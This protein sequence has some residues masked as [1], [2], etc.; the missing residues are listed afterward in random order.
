VRRR[1]IGL[2][3]IGFGVFAVTFGLMLRFYAYPQLAKLPLNPNQGAV[4]TGKASDLLMVL[5]GGADIRVHHDVPMTTTV[6]IEG[7]LL[8]PDA[9]PDGDITV[10]HENGRTTDD[11]GHVISAYN[12][13]M[14]INRSTGAEAVGCANG[15]QYV[16]NNQ[17]AHGRD[18]VT[19]LTPQGQ[20][21]TFP[22]NTQKH[23]YQTFDVTLGGPAQADYVG[24]DTINGLSVYKFVA[25][26]PQSRLSSQ[27]VPGSLVGLPQ[28]SSV[29]VDIYYSNVRT[30]WVEPLTGTPVQDQEQ[31]HQEMRVVNADVP[32]TVVYNATLRL[33]PASV[34]SNVDAAS[35]GVAGLTLLSWTAPVALGVAGIVIVVAGV[36]VMVLRRVS[37]APSPGSR[38]RSPAAPEHA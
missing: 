17:D 4:D 20:L 35:R 30:L 2:V 26:V 6:H 11:Q 16:S 7:N 5:D 24:D 19:P 22:F 23:S 37:A 21:Y 36:L 10:W 27:Q 12:R 9:K 32:P 14:C 18:I 28:Q 1:I 38:K 25:V 33:T 13:Q 34:Q 29:A 15:E 3:L 8:A 31:G